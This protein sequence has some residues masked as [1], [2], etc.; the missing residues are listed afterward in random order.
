[1][2]FPASFQRQHGGRRAFLPDSNRVCVGA[3]EALELL[4]NEP[5]VHAVS[6]LT[7][8]PKR[9]R[10]PSSTTLLR[11]VSIRNREV[12][13]Q[14]DAGK[15]RLKRSVPSRLRR[16]GDT[17]ARQMCDSSRRELRPRGQT[18]QTEQG[19]REYLKQQDKCR[20]HSPMTDKDTAQHA[21]TFPVFPVYLA[22]KVRGEEFNTTLMGKYRSLSYA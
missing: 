1:M 19:K 16:V 9:R 15:F 7:N 4:N 14:Y 2:T 21:I 13:G 11:D 3:T 17:E 18:G 8:H 20:V 22:R 6:T 12:K 5:R 10:R